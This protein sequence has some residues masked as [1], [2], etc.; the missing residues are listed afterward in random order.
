MRAAGRI[1][2]GKAYQ[3]DSIQSPTKPPLKFRQARKHGTSIYSTTMD[4]WSVR[5]INDHRSHRFAFACCLLGLEIIM[6]RY[7][8]ASTL[9][10][11]NRPVEDWG[12]LI[13]LCCV[14]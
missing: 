5:N 12:K 3:P 2:S 6:R 8:R 4:W 1:G 13:A 7:E 11:S 14:A 10:T 9:V